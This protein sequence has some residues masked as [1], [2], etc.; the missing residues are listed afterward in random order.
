LSNINNKIE[1]II[2]AA[3][4]G[5]RMRSGLPKVMHKVANRTLI[6]HSLHL[7]KSFS[8]SNVISVI[9]PGIDIIE[10]EIKKNFPESKICYQKEQ[11]GTGHAVRE[12]LGA[13]TNSSGYVVVLY[14]DTPFI[15]QDT[16]AKLTSCL[17][18]NPKAA[19]CVLA[20]ECFHANEYGRVIV[21]DGKLQKIVEFKDA[22]ESERK[23]TLCNSGI[24]AFKAE[25]IKEIVDRISNNNAKKEYYL[26]DAVE[27]ALA[28]N[29]EAECIVTDENEVLGI[30]SQAERDLAERLR[31][32][33]LRTQHMEN[34]VILVDSE[35]VYFSEDTMIAS[36]VVIHQ[37]VIFGEKVEVS[38]QVEIKP[39]SHI[40][41]TKI[42]K[43]SVVGPFA[44]LRPGTVLGEDNKIGN[45]VETKNIK[46]ENDVKVSHLSYIGDAV[47]ESA[48]NIGA[49]TITCNYDGKNKFTTHIEK[50]AFIGSNTALVAPV[51]V[52]YNSIIGAGST[53]W[54]DVP[55]ETT[56][57]NK[58]TQDVLKGNK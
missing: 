25:Y 18:K 34:G 17:E 45:F 43:G 12:S 13:L 28:S 36:G 27:I 49:G 14:G 48:V 52:G 15:R 5:T 57:V 54:K 56:T 37:N 41:G 8:G 38:S 32:K 33:Q 53:I 2:L 24:F 7:A 42:G 30:N 47:V 39:F 19:L 51:K 20:F 26:T 1:F 9:S 50:G 22:N 58:K 21:A 6:G 29:Y 40:E 35:T 31:Q 3:G 44:R 55:A 10:A 46:T 16:V 4:K 23:V 11:L